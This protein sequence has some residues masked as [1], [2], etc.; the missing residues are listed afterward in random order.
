MCVPTRRRTSFSQ[1]PCGFAGAGRR[2]ATL[3]RTPVT[4]SRF[5]SRL[6]SS[7]N[8]SVMSWIS[9]RNSGGC[10]DDER[11]RLNLDDKTG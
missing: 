9:W 7:P 4:V 10:V 1:R 3:A 6:A 2:H 11:S 5:R 8:T